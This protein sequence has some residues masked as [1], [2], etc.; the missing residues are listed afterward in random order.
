MFKGTKL[1]T[2]LVVTI[3]FMSINVFLTQHFMKIKEHLVCGTY[4]GLKES[5]YNFETNFIKFSMIDL[6]HIPNFKKV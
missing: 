3:G 5:Y 2:S 1:S 6:L 4:F